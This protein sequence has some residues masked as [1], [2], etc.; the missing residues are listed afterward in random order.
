MGLRQGVGLNAPRRLH[1]YTGG[2]IRSQLSDNFDVKEDK[3][4]VM[5]DL[6][7]EQGDP[8]AVVAQRSCLQLAFDDAG[9]GQVHVH[10]Q[11]VECANVVRALTPLYGTM[12]NPRKF[13]GSFEGGECVICLE[14]PK[15]VAILHCRHVC[16]CSSCAQ[17]T[18]STWR[19]PLHQ[20]RRARGP[21]EVR[22]V[23]CA[24]FWLRFGGLVVSSSGI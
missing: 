7:A 9:H 18:S 6:R 21:K 24:G 19:G 8:K 11:L 4:H 14:K 1:L 2:D 23:R 12:P 3:F 10:T 17:I 20:L 13:G 5:L 22:R 15:E 16:L